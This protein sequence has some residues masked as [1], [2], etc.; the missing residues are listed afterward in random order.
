MGKSSELETQL[1]V[2][3]ARSNRSEGCRRGRGNSSDCTGRTDIGSR[4]REVR[5]IK[6]V[7]E[8]GTEL[9]AEAFPNREILGNRQV[10]VGDV[11]SADDSDSSIAAPSRADRIRADRSRVRTARNLER[12]GIEPA[13][14]RLS[15]RV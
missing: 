9:N 1:E 14:D 3:L 5:M 11:R 4:K 12:R 10:G 7:G 2:D 8:V 13:V 15:R 6:Y